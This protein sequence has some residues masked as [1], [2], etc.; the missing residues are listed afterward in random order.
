MGGPDRNE[1]AYTFNVQFAT[2]KEFKYL[3]CGQSE[4]IAH[5]EDYLPI[6]SLH[7]ETHSHPMLP[8]KLDS[9]HNIVCSICKTA[10]DKLRNDNHCGNEGAGL[11]ARTVCPQVTHS[12]ST[13]AV[14]SVGHALLQRRGFV[15]K[16]VR[17][18]ITERI[19]LGADRM[20]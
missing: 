7:R 5:R 2:S 14:S 17:S 8:Q 20:F 10:H 16:P 12:F 18:R 19:E 15:P 4:V 1:L 13:G 9:P 6:G 3:V 11:G